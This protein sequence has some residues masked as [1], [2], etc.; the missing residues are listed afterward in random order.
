MN[1]NL[2][3]MKNLNVKQFNNLNEIIKDVFLDK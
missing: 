3:K 2:S 1:I